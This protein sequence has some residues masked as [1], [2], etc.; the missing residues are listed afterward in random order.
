MRPVAPEPRWGASPLM[1]RALM[2]LA[3]LPGS[4]HLVTP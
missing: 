2:A 3:F 4:W 1:Q